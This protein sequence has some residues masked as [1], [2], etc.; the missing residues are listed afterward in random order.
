MKIYP[1]IF[2]FVNISAFNNEF[3]VDTSSDSRDLRT[4]NYPTTRIEIYILQFVTCQ[5]ADIIAWKIIVQTKPAI[6]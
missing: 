2:R 6:V 5:F 1:M 4:L 3:H